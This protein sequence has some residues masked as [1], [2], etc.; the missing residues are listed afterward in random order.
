MP[1]YTTARSDEYVSQ[2]DAAND[3]HSGYAIYSRLINMAGEMVN[4]PRETYY[5]FDVSKGS[6]RDRFGLAWYPIN[7]DY[8]PGPPPPPR[9]P[10]EKKEQKEQK[11]ETQT[12]GDGE[13]QLVSSDPKQPQQ[14]RGFHR[15]QAGGLNHKPYRLGEVVPGSSSGQ[16]NRRQRPAGDKVEVN[17]GRGRGYAGAGPVR[18]THGRGRGR[19]DGNRIGTFDKCVRGVV[20]TLKSLII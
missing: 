15:Q 13:K 20:R 10:K 7:P 8:D 2:T 12:E 11:K 6:L 3:G 19:G 18:W 5:S 17:R 16:T 9:P 1:G 4:P 14:P